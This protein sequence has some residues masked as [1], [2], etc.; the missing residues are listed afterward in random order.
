MNGGFL[1]QMTTLFSQPKPV[2]GV[3]VISCDAEWIVDFWLRLFRV[4]GQI[5]KSGGSGAGCCSTNAIDASAVRQSAMQ[6]GQ[7]HLRLAGGLFANISG[8]DMT[9]RSGVLRSVP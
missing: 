4:V 2:V 8:L 7:Y 5:R 3:I 9:D 6:R 1:I